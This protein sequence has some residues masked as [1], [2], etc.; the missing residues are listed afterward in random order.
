[1]LYRAFQMTVKTPFECPELIPLES[2]K[3]TEEIQVDIAWGTT[4]LALKRVLNSGLY[5]TANNDEFLMDI[6]DVARFYVHSGKKI[7]IERYPGSDEDSIR[8]FLLGS[9]FGALLHQRGFWTL[10]ASAVH[11]E[12]GAVLIAGNSGA[13]KSTTMQSLIQKGYQNL[14]DDVT[15]VYCEQGKLFAL[16]S[17]PHSKIWDHTAK[18]INTDTSE[19]R[20]IRPGIDKYSLP[21][22]EHFRDEAS[23]IHALYMLVPQ[24]NSSLHLEEVKNVDRFLVLTH[25]TYRFQFLRNLVQE[26]RN[27][28]MMELF[29]KQCRITYCIRPK[30]HNTA[31][32]LAS[33]LETDFSAP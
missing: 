5:F 26:K 24:E 2:E 10:H 18:L 17:Y 31:A 25:E 9:A 8:L 12:K 15:A 6:E 33:L 13:G 29:S 16:P 32:A 7:I 11:T 4:P 20:R 30:E 28:A 3:S 19:L 22:Y 21:M 14:S 1:M 27:M 23:P